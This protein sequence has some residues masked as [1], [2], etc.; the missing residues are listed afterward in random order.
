M[1]LEKP[2]VYN[3]YIQLA[4]IQRDTI[5]YKVKHLA[6]NCYSRVK[7]EAS[8]PGLLLLMLIKMFN[9][10]VRR[11]RLGGSRGGPRDLARDL[12]MD[13]DTWVAA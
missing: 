5:P 13:Y 6:I 1:Y 2:P 7:G 4:S 9:S 8:R 10:Y 11:G 3:Q 12:V